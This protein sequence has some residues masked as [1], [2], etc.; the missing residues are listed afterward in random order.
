MQ[1]LSQEDVV[2]VIPTL[3]YGTDQTNDKINLPSRY[4]TIHRT[5][6][7]TC[8]GGGDLTYPAVNQLPLN[9]DDGML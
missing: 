3:Q 8:L 5:W 2:I 6:T 7:V 4:S 1:P 9:R